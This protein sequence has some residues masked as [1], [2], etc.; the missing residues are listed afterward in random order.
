MKR[1]SIPDVESPHS[2]TRHGNAGGFKTTTDLMRDPIGP[3]LDY[4]FLEIRAIE[5]LR[6]V[7]P[8]TGYRKQP[9]ELVE[10]EQGQQAP[11]PIYADWVKAPQEDLQ[12]NA[13]KLG[14][15]YL[16]ALPPV[17]NIIMRE[18]LEKPR[19]LSW[20]DLSFNQLEE[21]PAV[22]AAYVKL[23]VIYLHANRIRKLSSASAL[24]ELPNL[25]SLTLHGNPCEQTKNYK[26]LVYGMFKQIKS[27]DFSTITVIDREKTASFYARYLK[28]KEE[29]KSNK[30]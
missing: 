12:T 15:N 29:R 3:P 27:L 20:I 23:S 21:V 7:L 9:P 2:P 16:T 17:F 24:A 8:R 6:E 30:D 5:E 4:S 11:N 28:I 1:D 22:L 18:V 14:N 19:N 25:R 13:I 26:M 10:D